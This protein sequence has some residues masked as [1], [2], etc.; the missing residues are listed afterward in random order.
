[1]RRM[2]SRASTRSRLAPPLSDP[3]SVAPCMAPC[4]L[5]WALVHSP[6]SKHQQRG[7]EICRLKLK[8]KGSAA[9]SSSREFRYFAAVACYNQ[10]KYIEARRE[11]SALLQVRAAVRLDPCAVR[12]HHASPRCALHGCKFA[13]CHTMRQATQRKLAASACPNRAC[14]SVTRPLRQAGG[15]SLSSSTHASCVDL[16]FRA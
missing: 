12:V 10:G 15:R 13:A 3:L 6:H 2:A 14:S 16:G 11:V 8:D 7:L 4:R 5:V 1:M 9:S